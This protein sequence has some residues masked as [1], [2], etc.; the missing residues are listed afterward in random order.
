MDV[1]NVVEVLEHWAARRSLRAIGLRLGL[2]VSWR[3]PRLQ[4]PH[5][6]PWRLG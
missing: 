1:A 2:D 3:Q 6:R 4:S 5:G